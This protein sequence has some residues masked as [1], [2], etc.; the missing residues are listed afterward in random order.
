M[1]LVVC[2]LMART[3][4]SPGARARASVGSGAQ[5]ARVLAHHVPNAR[6]RSFTTPSRS[7]TTHESRTPSWALMPRIVCVLMAH[8][9]SSPGARA[10]VGWIWSSERAH[11]RPSCLQRTHALV[12]NALS[13]VH[14]ARVEGAVVGVDAAHCVHADGPHR[15]LTWSARARVGWVWS[16]RISALA[17]ARPSCPKCA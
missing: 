16:S 13:L 4:S 17:H 6:M 12:Y 2:V 9:G 8:T 14:D 15:Q 7:F 5:S 3:G 1:P 10:R 11:A